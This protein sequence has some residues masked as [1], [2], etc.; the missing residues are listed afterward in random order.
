[1]SGLANEL[2]ADI[3]GLSGGEEDDY[4]ESNEPR[5]VASPPPKGLKRKL[6]DD[7]DMS[8]MEEGV[9]EAGTDGQDVVGGLVLEGGVKPAEELDAEDVQQMDLAGIEDVGSVAK[10]E[11]SK[12]MAD[13]LKASTLT[14]SSMFVR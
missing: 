9:G 13:I 3:E 12:R 14:T 5:D 2:L 6:D 10:L 7:A 4:E 11:G 8:D 1:M